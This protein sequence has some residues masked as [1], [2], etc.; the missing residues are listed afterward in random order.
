[1]DPQNPARLRALVLFSFGLI[2]LFL[3]FGMLSVNTQKAPSAD[4]TKVLRCFL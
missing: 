2:L 1:M 3:A 4:P